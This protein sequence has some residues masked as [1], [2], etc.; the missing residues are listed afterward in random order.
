MLVAR[1]KYSILLDLNQVNIILFYELYAKSSADALTAMGNFRFGVYGS[2][3]QA[4]KLD[5]RRDAYWL[6]EI[7]RG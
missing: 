5:N 6:S 1:F 7:S 4:S 2:L 3:P